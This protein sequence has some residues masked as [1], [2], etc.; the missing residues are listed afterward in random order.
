MS[1]YSAGTVIAGLPAAQRVSLTCAGETVTAGRASIAADVAVTLYGED[2]GYT[3]SYWFDAGDFT[4]QPVANTRCAVDGIACMILGVQHY[5]GALRR[6]D[7]GGKY[8]G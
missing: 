8:A 6:L 5:P 3:G 4:A 1:V 2:A 7:V